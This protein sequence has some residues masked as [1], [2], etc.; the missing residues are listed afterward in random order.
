[1]PP[2]ETPT[3]TCAVPLLRIQSKAAVA[4]ALEAADGVSAL[5]VR[6]EAGYHLALVDIF[7]KRKDARK[8]SL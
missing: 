2:R 6:A 5:A 1:M 7:R 4:P 8:K 3:L